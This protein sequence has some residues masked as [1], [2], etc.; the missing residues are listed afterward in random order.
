MVNSRRDE[1]L[2]RVRDD[3]DAIAAFVKRANIPVEK[4][5]DR[6]SLDALCDSLRLDPEDWSEEF[7]ET[8]FIIRDGLYQLRNDLRDS[9]DEDGVHSAE[10]TRTWSVQCAP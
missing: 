3:V 7:F 2:R 5:L 4:V 9:D 8:I 6:I 1:L 10:Q